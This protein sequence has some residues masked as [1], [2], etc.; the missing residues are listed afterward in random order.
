MPRLPNSIRLAASCTLV[1]LLTGQLQA[2]SPG[3]SSDQAAART[4]L[5]IIDGELHRWREYGPDRVCIYQQRPYRGWLSADQAQ[6]L[7]GRSQAW[8]RS[9]PGGGAAVDV[10]LT[11]SAPA[12]S[13]TPS[14]VIGDSDERVRVG[15]DQLAE[16]PWRTVGFH[17]HDYSEQSSFRC[18]GTLIAPHLVLTNAHCIHRNQFEGRIVA[19]E[20]APAQFQ[21]GLDTEVIR[22]FGSA[23]AYDFVVNPDWLVNESSPHDYGALMLSRPFEAIDS[24]MPL[25]FDDPGHPV[26]QVA[27][28]PALVHEG[29]PSHE[30]WSK[31]QWHSTSTDAAVGTG[32]NDRLIL[33]DAD[34]SGGNSGSP[35]WR[36]DDGP[37]RIIGVH[38]CG[39]A[40]AQLNWGPRLRGDNLD[41]IEGWLNW[42]PPPEPDPADDF[43]MQVLPPGSGS[44]TAD[45]F[46]ATRQLTEPNHC[47]QQTG[48]SLWW[49]WR[50]P[51]TRQ[52]QFHLASD[53][54]D[55][56]LAIYQGEAL[57]ALDGLGCSTGSPTSLSIDGNPQ[58]DWHL[59]ID[60]I[61][62]TEGEFELGWA[63]EAPGNDEPGAAWPLIDNEG[64]Q[65]ADS[66][67]A[68]LEP[69]QADR[70]CGVEVDGAVWWRV[71]E[72]VTAALASFSATAASADLVLALLAAGQDLAEPPLA[73][74]GGQGQASLNVALE[75]GAAYWL[76]VGTGSESDF[77]LTWLI[78]S[79]PTVFQD[80]FEMEAAGIR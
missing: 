55:P 21:A 7:Q 46:G 18:T 5:Q 52:V 39:S 35:I 2:L 11:R 62:R 70:V 78:Q 69:T 17:R 37:A 19:S 15:L 42:Q 29:T 26:I 71:D 56:V 44:L 57:D 25:V 54:F 63:I 45:N 6:V 60:G 3:C 32:A 27:G 23:P 1:L 65:S 10:P 66:W 49:R 38:C 31:A 76:M 67:G 59:A 40:I 74:A 75:S 77:D 58:A 50:A 14:A 12:E 30:P 64:S 43:G 24:F 9:Q 20:F 36:D 53:S 41:I 4:V 48:R 22:P 13:A 33:H 73:C 79:G 68:G 61:D 34:T 28:Y 47:G 51:V 16:H 72:L 80:R 8:Q